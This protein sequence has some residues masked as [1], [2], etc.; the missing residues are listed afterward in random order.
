MEDRRARIEQAAVRL[1]AERGFEAT[2][3]GD[4]AALAGVTRPV[5]YDH[6]GSKVQLHLL[7]LE[8]ERD[9]LVR[10]VSGRLKAGGTAR[11]R[12][13]SA[14]EAFFATVERHPYAWRMLF[15]DT[16]GVAELARR[17][18]EIQSEAHVAVATLLM[19]GSEAPRRGAATPR[20]VEMLAAVWGAGANGLARWWYEHRDVSRADVV[21]VAMD[22]LW[23]GLDGMPWPAR[24]V[25]RAQSAA[26]RR[27]GSPRSG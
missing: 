6:F 27:R 7:L 17:Q 18:R 4:I 3:T 24:G 20:R 5:F 13:E 25:D 8:R 1:F 22:A 26:G 9:R 14:L 2:S 12:V 10:E 15:H 19:S 23:L 11:A 21:A 16:V